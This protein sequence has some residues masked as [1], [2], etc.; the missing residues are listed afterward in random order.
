MVVSLGGARVGALLYSRISRGRTEQVHNLCFV[1][2]DERN[3]MKE[4][5]A[6]VTFQVVGARNF[7]RGDFDVDEEEGKILGTQS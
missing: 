3:D 5:L 6:R 1:Y 2:I 7:G 4:T